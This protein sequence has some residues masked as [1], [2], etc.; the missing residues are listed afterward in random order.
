MLEKEMPTLSPMLI[1]R[2]VQRAHMLNYLILG[3]GA[4]AMLFPFLW[5]VAT[6]FK[7]RGEIFTFPPTLLPQTFTLQN[8]QNL[9]E[10][11]DVARLFWNTALVAVTKTVLMV[12]T[13]AILGYVFGKYQFRGRDAIFYLILVT[14]ILPLEVYVIPLY[15]MMAGA[16]L[17]DSY[18]ALILPYVFS[19]YS[20]FL[21]RQFVF[22]IPD[23][24]IDA[25]RI[26]GASEL[27]VFHRVI[28]P[29]SGPVLATTASF[30]FMWN[31][32][33]FLWPLIIIST[34]DKAMLPVALAGFVADRGTDY[35]LIMAGTTFVVLPV[36]AVFL[37]F[38][39]YIVQ[40]IALTGMK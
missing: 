36:L 27:Y 18:A 30:Y 1:W 37:L 34:R 3:I 16:K 9:F 12:Y 38:Q 5:M 23:E 10:R 19:A 21:F 40:G 26:D 31:W 39:R 8:Y 14:M 25:A 2:R 22:A 35:G 13:S 17:A 6:S 29:L 4:A 24:L 7:V 28:L 20:I 11:L 15:Q 32:N 33:D